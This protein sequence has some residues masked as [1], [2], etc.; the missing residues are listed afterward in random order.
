MPELS[1][2]PDR[3]FPVEPSTREVARHLYGEV[4]GLPI[5]SPHGHTD[6]AW[7]AE[8]QPFTCEAGNRVMGFP[9]TVVRV[10]SLW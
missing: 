9:K 3:L 5:I 1:L 8:N 4:A 7:F 6:P 2:H 10:M